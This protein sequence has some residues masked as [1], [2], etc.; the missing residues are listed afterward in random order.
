MSR[1]WDGA[2][3]NRKTFLVHFARLDDMT[4]GIDINYWDPRSAVAMDGSTT[5]YVEFVEIN[6]DET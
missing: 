2:T 5:M 4:R 1:P 3:C 6:Y